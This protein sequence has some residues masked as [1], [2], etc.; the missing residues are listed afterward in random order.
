MKIWV[1][2]T[3]RWW[4]LLTRFR[5]WRW[6]RERIGSGAPYVDSLQDGLDLLKSRDPLTETI[7]FYLAPGTHGAV[8]ASIG[9]EVPAGGRT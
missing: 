7:T 2:S 6:E 1:R 9:C 5:R 3:V 4:Q 8:E